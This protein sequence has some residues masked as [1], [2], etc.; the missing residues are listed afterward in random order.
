MTRKKAVTNNAVAKM[1]G[2]QIIELW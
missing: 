1:D 2:A